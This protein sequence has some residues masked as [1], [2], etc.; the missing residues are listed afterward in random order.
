MTLVH[1]VRSPAVDFW[2]CKNGSRWL[3]ERAIPRRGNALRA[4]LVLMRFVL[5]DRI[6]E[7]E[8]ERRIVTRKALAAGEEYLADHFPTFPVMP[9]VLMLEALVQ[10]AAFLV[11]A[12]TDFRYSLV[13]LR[14]ARNVNYRTFVAPGDV[15]ELEVT[16]RELGEQSSSFSGIGRCGDEQVVKA[17]LTLGH[18]RLADQ[19]AALAERDARM[20]ADNRARFERLGGPAAMIS[21]V[22]P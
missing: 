14:E 1:T 5:I 15:L 13:L 20:V 8:P 19:N 22:R 4:V 9:G 16:V 18:E 21:P 2:A 10:S 6:L 7:V 3:H 17:R 11:H 12:S